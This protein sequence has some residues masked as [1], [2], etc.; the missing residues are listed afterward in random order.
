M[1]SQ[2]NWAVTDA[3]NLTF[4]IRYGEDEAVGGSFSQVAEGNNISG[5]S[6][7]QSNYNEQGLEINETSVSPKFAVNYEL[8]SGINIYAN[9]AKGFKAGGLD[10]APLN[11][12]ALTFKGE[13]A[14]TYELGMK[15]RLAGGSLTLNLAVF[16]TK[17]DN[18]QIRTF[19]GVTLTTSNAPKSS[20]QGAELDFF[21]L[22]PLL[23][24]SIAGSIGY[25][26]ARYDEFPDG[27]PIFSS[28]NDEGQDLAGKPLPY[29]PR[30]NASLSPKYEWELFNGAITA[31][32][33]LNV[34][35]TDGRFLDS[36]ID[37]NTFQPEVTRIDLG[38][39]I[40]S[41]DRR[42][43]L[44]FQARNVNETQD[45]ILILDQ[46]LLPGNYTQTPLA[47]QTTYQVDLRYN[48]GAEAS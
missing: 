22:P 4:G 6:L 41:A 31:N 3:L 45:S 27:P 1:F 17:V 46:P 29:A 24:S 37:P 47:D 16:D 33:R 35:Y 44:N 8:L 2:L 11:D 40:N 43:K 14:I 42:W 30:W 23:G 36:D 25:L 34:S 32:V 5:G 15:S 9:A 18:L 48:F 19:N 10:P 7:N 21:W 26:E 28:G 20:S 13:E 39:G 12:D 38:F